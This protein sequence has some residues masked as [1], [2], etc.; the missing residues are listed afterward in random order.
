[1]PERS[2]QKVVTVKVPVSGPGE[3]QRD[4]WSTAVELTKDGNRITLTKT[5]GMSGAE[6]NFNLQDLRE[7]VRLLDEE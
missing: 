7:A 1:M 3:G 6:W 4:A 2:V 5:A